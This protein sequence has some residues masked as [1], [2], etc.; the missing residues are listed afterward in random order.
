MKKNHNEV[1]TALCITV[2][3]WD[4]ESWGTQARLRKFCFDCARSGM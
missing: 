1:M 4:S 2:R 3:S